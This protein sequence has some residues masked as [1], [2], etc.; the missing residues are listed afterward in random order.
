MQESVLVQRKD[1][2]LICF[3]VQGPPLCDFKF[4]RKI[5]KMRKIKNK[6]AGSIDGLEDTPRCY[7]HF[8]HDPDELLHNSRLRQMDGENTSACCLVTCSWRTTWTRSWHVAEI[9][10][11]LLGQIPK[12][13]AKENTYIS[14]TQLT[15]RYFDVALNL[16]AL[17]GISSQLVATHP[18]GNSSPGGAWLHSNLFK[19]WI[20]LKKKGGNARALWVRKIKVPKNK[21][22]DPKC[23]N[24]QQKMGNEERCS[25]L[26]VL[27]GAASMVHTQCRLCSYGEG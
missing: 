11:A 4:T 3:Q 25:D 7:C 27:P 14:K 12:R 16:Q 21:L 8:D 15:Q 18:L 6:S 5:H 22:C 17:R 26:M 19:W 20:P 24:K 2:L 1:F 9:Q 13:E 23:N 10:S